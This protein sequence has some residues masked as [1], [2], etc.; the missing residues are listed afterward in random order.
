M[1]TDRT[2]ELGDM[3][4]YTNVGDNGRRQPEPHPAIITGIHSNGDVALHVIYKA[5]SFDMPRVPF[6]SRPGVGGT[7]TWRPN[8]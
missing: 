3:V 6:S 5:G 4:H 1:P 8:R 7:W 2:P